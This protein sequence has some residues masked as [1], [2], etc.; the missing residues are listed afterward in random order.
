MDQTTYPGP[1]TLFHVRINAL[2][3]VLWAVD[4]VMFAFAVESTLTH[5]VGGMVLFASEVRPASSFH[6]PIYSVSVVSVQYAILLASALNAILRYTLSLLDLRR[7]RTRGGENAPPWE[8]K[9][10]YTFYIDLLTGMLFLCQTRI[11][12]RLNMH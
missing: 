6:H 3:F 11:R 2:F 12:L 4:T 8:N 5:G 7:A 1:P 9:S 10:M